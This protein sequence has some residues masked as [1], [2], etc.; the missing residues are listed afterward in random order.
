MRAGAGAVGDVDRVREPGERQR[1]AQQILRLA[2]DWR[3]DLG[4]DG[5]LPRPQ[6]RFQT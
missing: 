1:L 6:Q 2:G 4:G 5:E 3:R